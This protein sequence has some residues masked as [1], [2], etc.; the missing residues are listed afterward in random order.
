MSGSDRLPYYEIN[1]LKIEDWSVV[2]DG[3]LF[4]A[5][6][7]DPPYGL[8]FMGKEWDK[9]T[10]A[11]RRVSGTGGTQAP[12]A[13]HAAKLDRKRM[14]KFQQQV[15]AWGEAILPLLYPG[16]LVMMF[17]G[18]RTWHRLAAGMEDAGFEMWDT[19]MWLHG[20]GFPKAQDLGTMIDKVK[21]GCPQ[22]VADPESPN[23]G[24]WT[25]GCTADNPD[26]RGMGAGV[27]PWGGEYQQRKAVN[28]WSGH[29]TTALKPA[30]EPILCFKKPLDGTYAEVALKYGSGALNVDGGRIGLTEGDDPRL[31]GKGD[32]GTEAAAKNVYEGGYAGDRVGSSPLGRYPANLILDEESAAMLDEQTGDSQ[33]RVGKPR[34]SAAPGNGWGMTHT[35]S[36]YEDHGGA[37]RFF[38]CAKASSAERE[39]GLREATVSDGRETPADNPY[40]R[41]ATKRYNLHPTV[42]PIA[43]C[44]YL[45][46]LLL[47]PVSIGERRLLVPFSGSG[48]EMIGALQA[49]WDEVVGVESDTDHG[50]CAI[51]EARVGHHWSKLVE[52]SLA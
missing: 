4:H 30:W 23:H 52:Q 2:Y 48:S 27:S 21:R 15:S 3:E 16:A 45:A 10:E 18:T 31:G 13:N 47:P 39:A 25:G 17:G 49:G 51:A 19:L 33:S 34:S 28:E 42:K 36:E 8:E 35:G 29:K 26:G 38:Y 41:G 44:K 7:C 40:Q 37:S 24:K 22:G 1:N 50:Y 12:F 32:W 6:L 5:V 43:L 9:F 11:P 14:V 20:Q 46:T